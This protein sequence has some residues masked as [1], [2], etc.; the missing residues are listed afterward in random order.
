MACRLA[1]C[2]SSRS[3]SEIRI[4]VDASSAYSMQS[5]SDILTQARSGDS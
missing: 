3:A 5:R 2:S 1:A 4:F